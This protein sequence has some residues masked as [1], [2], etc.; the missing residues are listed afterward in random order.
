MLSKD[1]FIELGWKYKWI[2][3]P[4][5]VEGYSSYVNGAKRISQ[6][7]DSMFLEWLNSEGSICILQIRIENKEE[8]R[9]L[10]KMLGIYNDTSF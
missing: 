8:L 5:L 10:M 9:L 2:N 1:D 4:Q 3:T 7:K 6:F